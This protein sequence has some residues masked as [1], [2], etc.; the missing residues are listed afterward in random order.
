MDR[1]TRTRW[2]AGA[3]LALAVL[4]PGCD[5]ATS[6]QAAQT[7]VQ[8]DAQAQDVSAQ[9]DLSTVLVAAKTLFVQGSSYTGV[10]PATLGSAEPGLCYVGASTPSVATGAECEAGG[11]SNSLSVFA[12]DTTFAAA[13]RSDSGTCFWVRD[14]LGSGTTY[15]AGEPCTGSAATAAAEPSFPS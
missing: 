4:A 15:G 6:G 2:L 7:G 5:L 1:S 12:Q 11:G 3:T 8:A 10:T 13:A 9:S 14:A